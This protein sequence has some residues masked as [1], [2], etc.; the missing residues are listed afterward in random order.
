[1]KEARYTY[2][3][4]PVAEYS[5]IFLAI[6]AG[7]MAGW[8]N[9]KI[10]AFSGVIWFIIRPPSSTKLLQWA[11]LIMILVSFAIALAQLDRAND[12]LAVFYLL[13]VGALVR[14]M[15]EELP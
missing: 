11:L 10:L 12:L 9:F 1:M 8:E 14:K 4:V 5:L 3:R 6:L 2:T 7:F 15:H 13:I